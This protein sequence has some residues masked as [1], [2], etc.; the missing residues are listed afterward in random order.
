MQFA[1]PTTP[2]GC[3]LTGATLRM[4]NSSGTTGRTIQVLRVTAAWNET[5]TWNTQP[6]TTGT[7]ATATSS[8]TV[9]WRTWTITAIV[10][11]M[12]SGT[13]N[14]LLPRDATENASTA[15]DQRYHSREAANDPELVVTFG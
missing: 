12:Y 2:S 1:L 5:V 8:T 4:Y 14:G 15:Q 11:A 6:A 10:Q 13:N 7:A 3:T 9:G